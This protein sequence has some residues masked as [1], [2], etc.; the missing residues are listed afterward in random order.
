[1]QCD[2]Q[3]NAVGP[4]RRVL[5]SFPL[6]EE[7][8]GRKPECNRLAF[9]YYPAENYSLSWHVLIGTMTVVGPYCKALE[10]SGETKGLCC[11]TG[12]IKLPQL[13]ETPEPLKI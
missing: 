12:K 5:C 7:P 9:R 4:W 11:A 3:I 10:F 13:R 2:K 6:G 1:M 8:L